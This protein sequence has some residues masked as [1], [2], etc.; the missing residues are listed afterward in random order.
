MILQ[1]LNKKLKQFEKQQQS[2]HILLD[3]MELICDRILPI[4]PKVYLK[5][6]KVIFYLKYGRYLKGIRR[7]VVLEIQNI[8]KEYGLYRQEEWDKIQNFI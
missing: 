3:H 8:E 6:Q 7:K 1:W 4:Y 2:C 5:M